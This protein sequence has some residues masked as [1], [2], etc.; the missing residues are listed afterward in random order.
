M[1]FLKWSQKTAKCSL[2]S[3]IWKRNKTLIS[4]SYFGNKVKLLIFCLQCSRKI[5]FSVTGNENIIS[6][7]TPFNA[8]KSLGQSKLST[9]KY[10]NAINNYDSGQHFSANYCFQIGSY[11]MIIDMK[12][13]LFDFVL[14][15]FWQRF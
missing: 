7:S 11:E 13:H 2:N 8:H 3:D 12:N 5:S 10:T 14:L 15:L 6:V 4:L 1:A 9:T